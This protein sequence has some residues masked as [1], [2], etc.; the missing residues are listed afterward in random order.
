MNVQSFVAKD[1]TTWTE[2]IKNRLYHHR[3][4][5]SPILE[6]GNVNKVSF[7]MIFREA[8]HCVLKPL[9]HKQKRVPYAFFDVS[10]ICL[11]YYLNFCFDSRVIIFRRLVNN[12]LYAYIREFATKLRLSKRGM[13]LHSMLIW[14]VR[15]G[16]PGAVLPL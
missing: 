7:E 11:L 13:P 1:L 10:S 6:D 12:M 15:L 2:K 16:S 4:V 14:S 8:N 5:F 3:R 9:K